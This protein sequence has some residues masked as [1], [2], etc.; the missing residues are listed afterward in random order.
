[1]TREQKPF[2]EL[3][4]T[5]ADVDDCMIDM[6]RNSFFLPYDVMQFFKN[7][8]WKIPEIQVVTN[9][10]FW[11]VVPTLQKLA[12]TGIVFLPCEDLVKDARKVGVS[13]RTSGTNQVIVIAKMWT[14]ADRGG[15]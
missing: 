14:A 9:E 15:Y 11:R 12:E 7:R 6:L 1:M 2:A 13:I 4:T 10:E 8:G 5:Q 3:L